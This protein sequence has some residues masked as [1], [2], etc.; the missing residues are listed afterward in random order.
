MLLSNIEAAKKIPH[1]LYKD[2]QLI[3]VAGQRGQGKTY[4]IQQYL[5]RREPRVLAIDP[6]RDFTGLETVTSIEEASDALGR[7]GHGRFRLDGTAA[8]DSVE[9]ANE[10]FDELIENNRNF[11]LVLDEITLWSHQRESAVFRKIINQGRRWGIRTL[12]ACQRIGGIPGT[13]L[14]QCTDLVLFRTSP[15]PTDID[16]VRDWTDDA[17]AEEVKSLKRG[18]CLYFRLDE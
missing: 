15:R 18:E 3:V 10:L 5:E 9:W 4:L 2:P 6:F 11:L 12:V 14:S 8:E 13:V 17:T 7:S 1:R 16:T